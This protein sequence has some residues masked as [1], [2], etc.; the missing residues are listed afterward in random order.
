MPITSLARWA[1][2]GF[3][4]LV[5]GGGAYGQAA[6]ASFPL[7]GVKPVFV[8]NRGQFREEVRFR[9]ALPG[10][11]A[12]VT[13]DGLVLTV[14]DGRTRS[15]DG[16]LLA[17]NVRL[18][19][20]AAVAA[21]GGE[22]AAASCSYFLGE[23]DSRWL[24]GVPCWESVRLDGVANGV[25][26]EVHGRNG[27]V[28]YDILVEP[29]VAA[30]GIVISVEGADAI[31]QRADGSLDILTP[32]GTIRQLPPRAWEVG[33][34]GAQ[35]NLAA[36]LIPREFGTFG[37]EITDR[38]TS[39]LLVIDPGLVYGTFVEGSSNDVGKSIAVDAQGGCYVA[40]HSRSLDFPT[41]PGSFQ[42]QKFE[43]GT[44]RDVVVA[45]LTPDGSALDFATY[46]GGTGDD[47]AWRMT[48]DAEGQPVIVGE[49]FSADFPTTVGAYAQTGWGSDG[50]LAKL[51]ATGT[52]LVFS[53]LFGGSGPGGHG[54][55]DVAI[56]ALGRVVV[57]GGTQFADLP[58]TANAAQP[59]LPEPPGGFIVRFLPDGS[60]IDYCTY[61]GSSNDTHVAVDDAMAIYA[62]GYTTPFEGLPLTPGAFQTNYGGGTFDDAFVL[63]LAADGGLEWCTLLGG[64]DSDRAFGL[65]VDIHGQP[66]VAGWTD[67]TS[68]TFPTT[69][70]SFDPIANGGQD[71]FITK[72]AADG[73]SLVWS[74]RFGGGSNDSLSDMALDEAGNC[75]IVGGTSSANLPVTPNAFDSSLNGSI[76]AFVSKLSADGTQLLYGTFIG[77]TGVVEPANAVAVDPQGNA[78]I[79]GYT[80]STDIPTTPG[81]FDT[82]LSGFNGIYVAKFD[83]ST[84]QSVGTGVPSGSGVMPRLLASGTLQPLTPG[85]LHVDQA[86]PGELCT[87]IF[88]LSSL[89]LPF[90]G[91]TMVPMPALL[92]TFV[93]NGQGKLNLT[94][95]AWPAIVPAG[96]SLWFQAWIND[97]LA[98]AGFAATNGLTATVPTPG[99]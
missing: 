59:T 78:Y 35:R 58:I 20:G 92:L 15:A 37:F 18:R 42:P 52:Q 22:R 7:K 79:T 24:S 76:D 47:T 77:G 94:W 28:E 38:D 40:G 61:I 5:L 1:G 43:R 12:T 89:G 67:S 51:N 9:T 95:P 69:P 84:W 36:R 45:K 27:L 31:A 26:V 99:G 83:L 91:G 96:T 54:L 62:A 19:F 17:Q 70:E 48:V 81:A 41:T 50:F 53:T 88:G 97:P 30:E 10:S 66:L 82:E 23:D 98:I 3:S 63:K 60:D 33:Q 68:G 21:Q 74:T 13:D 72:F 32:T 8:E 14:T 16:A 85:S 64:N 87:L 4:A 6:K 56:D 29:G 80:S 55:T 75:Y 11:T 71:G 46:I 49:A 90:K 73:S 34:D 25:S 2:V 93:L 86:P 57:G 39:R 44:W 65:G